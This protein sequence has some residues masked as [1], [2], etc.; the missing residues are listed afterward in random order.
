MT[1]SKLVRKSIKNISGKILFL[2]IEKKLQMFED[3]ALHQKPKTYTSSTFINICR[4]V[5]I[6]CVRSTI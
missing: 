2:A 1:L 3:K 4:N 6:F 5:L